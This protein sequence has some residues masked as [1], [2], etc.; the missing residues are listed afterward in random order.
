MTDRYEED[1]YSSEVEENTSITNPEVV[2]KYKFAAAFAT[3]ALKAIYKEAKKGSSVYELCCLGDKIIT[4]ECS[5]VYCKKGDN[6][7]DKGIAFPTCISVNEAVCHFSP[8]LEESKNNQVL[9]SGDVVRIDLGCH[10]D[11]YCSV[12]ADTFVVGEAP[13]TGKQADVILAAHSA[14]DIVTRAL[15]PGVSYYAI[16]ELMEKVA[17]EYG[18][19]C[20]EGVFSHRMSRYII[21]GAHVIAGKDVPEGKVRDMEIEENEVWAIDILMTTGSGKL[22]ERDQRPLVFKKSLDNNYQLKLQASRDVFNEV[23]QRFQTFPFSIR[24]LDQKR[25]RIG[26]QEC[27]RNEMVDPYPILYERDGECVAHVK[28]S[29]LVT[30]TKI[31]NITGAVFDESMYKSECQIRDET[32]LDWQLKSLKLKEKKANAT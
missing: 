2:Q 14:L 31:E 12:T 16:T 5:K 15:R 28:C 22:K 7:V 17:K 24:H 6:R 13:I 27:L 18:V 11:G 20:V 4:E 19:N 26:L 8:D 10:V 25:G 9:S 29:V 21:D 32:L 3:K 1:G 30:P 23:N